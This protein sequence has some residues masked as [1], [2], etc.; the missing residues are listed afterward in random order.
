MVESETAVL[1]EHQK[2]LRKDIH[3]NNRETN[4]KLSFE[5]HLKARTMPDHGRGQYKGHMMDR[6]VATS[7]LAKALKMDHIPEITVKRSKVDE[8]DSK[9]KLGLV[10]RDIPEQFVRDDTKRIVTGK[11]EK[12]SLDTLR[13]TDKKI[14]DKAVFDYLIGNLDRHHGNYFIRVNGDDTMDMLGFD[15]GLSFPSTNINVDKF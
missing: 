5:E 3:L 13:Q 7:A 11:E 9:N 1:K 2:F 15:H 4:K 14:G 12:K 6:E 8:S 10:V